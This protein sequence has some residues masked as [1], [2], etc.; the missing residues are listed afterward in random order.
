MAEILCEQS[1]ILAV[2]QECIKRGDAS[3]TRIEGETGH[4]ANNAQ[5]DRER[6]DIGAAALVCL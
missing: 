1:R 6:Q 4:L 2:V 3:W 5:D